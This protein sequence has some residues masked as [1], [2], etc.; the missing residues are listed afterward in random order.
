MFSSIPGCG[1][2]LQG[3][4]LSA[5]AWSV[6]IAS[7][8][9]KLSAAGGASLATFIHPSMLLQIVLCEGDQASWGFCLY[10]CYGAPPGCPRLRLFSIVIAAL[11]SSQEQM[12]MQQGHSAGCPFLLFAHLHVK[13]SL[14]VRGEHL[15]PESLN[16]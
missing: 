2:T 6:V 9:P 12:Q 11:Q 4:G 15:L 10:M 1:G 16:V 3:H 14:M 8:H 13:T 7:R 5:Q